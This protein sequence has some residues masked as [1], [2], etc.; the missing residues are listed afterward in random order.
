MEKIFLFLFSINV[1]FA[2][3]PPQNLGISGAD[4]MNPQTCRRLEPACLVWQSNISGNWDIFSRFSHLGAWSDTFRI[5]TDI[6]SDIN[7][8]V[9]KGN[10]FWCVWQNNGAGNW[11][12]YAAYGD[13][14]NGWSTPYQISTD[15]AE[16]ENPSV[17]VSSDTVWAVWQKTLVESVNIY[18]SFYDGSTW[19]S[20]I[21]L[22][23]DSGGISNISPKING[24]NTD[25]FVVWEREGDIYYTEYIDGVWQIPQSI[26]ADVHNDINPEIATTLGYDVCVVWQSDR[27]G[28]YEIYA[29]DTDNFGIHYRLTF[30]DSVDATPSPLSYI[31]IGT[32]HRYGPS[33][34]A[35]STKRN[36]NYDIYSYFSGNGSNIIPVDTCDAED[37][38]PTTTQSSN[39]YLWVLWQTDR[40]T[41]LDIYGSYIDMGNAVEESNSYG[42]HS[43]NSLTIKP[44]PFRQITYIR[45]RNEVISL[46]IYDATGRLINQLMLYTST[47][48]QWGGANSPVNQ[49]SWDGTDQNG[50]RLSEGVYF[51][52][53]KTQSGINT[54]KV[55][56]L[57]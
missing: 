20:P 33:F 36:G 37:V 46:K 56:L 38:L 42:I 12:I 57:E 9:A 41:D 35:F 32:T 49:V 6:G 16:E 28:N 15:P 3:S 19:S 24:H 27:D 53:L 51:V 52:Q 8:S 34:T 54:Q 2:W 21:P 30:H 44:N 23:I 18:V 1:L 10:A 22:T 29:T 26:T 25:P 17:Y 4:D 31:E 40:N 39:L 7:P 43:T 55:V 50:K 13:T 14:L 48:A 5:T 47:H 45:Y 11:D